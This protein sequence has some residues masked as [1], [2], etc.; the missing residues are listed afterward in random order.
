MR[1]EEEKSPRKSQMIKKKKEK[2]VP[3]VQT[4]PANASSL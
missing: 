1:I 4:K 3:D 2:Q